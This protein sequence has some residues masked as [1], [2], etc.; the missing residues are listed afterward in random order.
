MNQREE[1]QDLRNRIGTVM[2]D[3]DEFQAAWEGDKDTWAHLHDAVEDL[4]D[5]RNH[6]IKALQLWREW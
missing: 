3:L 5:A 6:V 4:I 2:F 1:L